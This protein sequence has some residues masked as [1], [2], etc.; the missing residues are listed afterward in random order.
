M[1]EQTKWTGKSRECFI[2]AMVLEIDAGVFVDSGFKKASWQKIIAVLNASYETEWEASEPKFTFTKQQCQS[3]YSKIKSQ[4]SI[5][6]MLMNNSGF[7]RDPDTAD[8]PAC[9]SVWNAV[10]AA[11]KDAA[12]YFQSRIKCPLFFEKLR[13]SDD[14]PITP[15]G[16]TP[17]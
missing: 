3:Y 14:K 7:G 10:T 13:W 5:Y 6:D 9:D 16:P 1:A 2:K 12:N 15:H 4:W 17:Y 8:P 11:H